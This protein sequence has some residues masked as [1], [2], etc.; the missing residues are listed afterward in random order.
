MKRPAVPV[1][2]FLP[3]FFRSTMLEVFPRAVEAP[4]AEVF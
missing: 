1:A 3:V 2:S 4:A